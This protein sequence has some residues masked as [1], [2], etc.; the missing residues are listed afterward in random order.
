MCACVFTQRSHLPA[1]PMFPFDN[2]NE[3]VQVLSLGQCE[4]ACL[5]CSERQWAVPNEEKK[6]RVL[7]KLPVRRCLFWILVSPSSHRRR[8]IPSIPR[9]K[10]WSEPRMNW[11]FCSW[12]R[13]NF[14]NWNK[15]KTEPNRTSLQTPSYQGY[16]TGAFPPALCCACFSLGGRRCLRSHCSHCRSWSRSCFSFQP[17]K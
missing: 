7:R 17:L 8:L 2:R 5:S 13:V 14:S 4:S 3:Y 15:F 10:N 12:K 9:Q 11:N 1:V 6:R 16:I